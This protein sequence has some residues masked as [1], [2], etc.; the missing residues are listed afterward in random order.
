MR[1]RMKSEMKEREISKEDGDRWKARW[2]N[3]NTHVEL[4]EMEEGAGERDRAN[5]FE[6]RWKEKRLQNA[7]MQKT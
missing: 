7:V 4:N 1:K 6:W 2:K 5:P 3:N